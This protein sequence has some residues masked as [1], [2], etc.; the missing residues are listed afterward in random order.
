MR[1]YKLIDTIDNNILYKNLNYY[2]AMRI[3]REYDSVFNQA[4]RFK[5]EAS[6]A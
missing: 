6:N 1:L 3:K 4:F 5:I 2:A